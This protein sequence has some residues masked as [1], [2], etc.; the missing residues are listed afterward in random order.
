[1]VFQYND[2]DEYE[3]IFEGYCLD[4]CPKCN[5]FL[6]ISMEHIK[7]EISNRF[8]DIEE[9]PMLKC[10]KCGTLHYTEYAKE[11]L[12]G[13]YKELCKRG[14]YGVKS[15]PNGYRKKYNYAVENNF[16][17]DHRDYESVPGLKFDDEHSEV[18]FLTPVYFDRKALLYFISDPVYE[19]DI[20]SETY[21]NI[22][23]KDAEGIYK[24]QWAVPFGFN[25]NGKIVFWL[26][27]LHSMDGFSKGI[28]RNFNIESD[29]LIINSEFY[30]AQMNCIFS[31]LI[32][33]QQILLNK[34]I[35]IQ[36]I[37]D[38]YGIDLKH[39]D[40]ECNIQ[41]KN[42]KRPIV[43]NE[44]SISGVIN[45][46]DKILV[47]GIN[48]QQ[49]RVLYEKMYNVDSSEKKHKEWKSIRLLKE[50]LIKLS[51]SLD[52]LIDIEN[53]ISPLYI[54]HDYRIYLD[55]LLPEEEQNKSKQHIA[56]TLGVNDFSEQEKIYYEEIRRLDVLFQY[57]ILLSK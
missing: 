18:G 20:F 8:M 47:E 38:K 15:K 48:V 56:E 22:A 33:E 17:Y 57:L 3:K 53:L 23:K 28:L 4:K 35:F 51:T 36:N 42:V 12:Y 39:L 21:G 16:I 13:L 19:V 1:M 26:G 52:E 9:I 45:A 5:G 14:E 46:F 54:L 43:F 32:K 29:H 6:E 10:G 24:Y 41:S 25:I 55:H 11:I 7:V 27:D 44:Q 2:E 31:E 37:Q 49:L 40:E 34:E 30:Q 50:I